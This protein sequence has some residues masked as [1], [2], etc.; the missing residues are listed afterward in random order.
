MNKN[1]RNMFTR[2]T[3]RDD[4]SDGMPLE[5]PRRNTTVPALIVAGMF[6]IFAA[7]LVQQVSRLNLHALGSIFELMTMLFELFWVLGWSVGV[8]ALAALT[9]FLLFFGESARVA[10]GRLIYVLNV[11]PFKMITEYELAR[12]RNL[13][14]EAEPDG[15]NARVRFE[16][17]EMRRG[18]GDTMPTSIAERNL[19]ILNSAMAGVTLAPA[20]E[21]APPPEFTPPKFEPPAELAQ[22]PLPLLS[23]LVLVAAN[24]IP[25]L[26]VL[27]GGWTLAEV[28]VLFWAESAVIGFYTLLKITVVAKWW[29]PFP[30]LFF[31]GHFGGFM[32]IHFLFIYELFVRGIN[33]ASPAPAAFEALAHMFTPLWIAFLALFLSHGVS[34]VVNFLGHREYENTT[35]SSLMQAPY[36]RIVVMQ[37]TLI[38]GGWVV[39]LLKDP[40]PALLL[41]IVI[42]VATDLRGHYGERASSTR[43]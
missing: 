29:A 40:M 15:E 5:L 25:L 12:V 28:M 20:D 10:R 1:F 38:L 33:A 36:G 4:A 35:V 34:F 24:L 26:S 18:L 23:M 30:G 27:M 14:I 21:F 8:L 7:V 11:G 41:L 43:K 6:A 2:F 32:A 9:V 42:K 13:R 3:L 22:R 16:Y 39:M 19:G 31:A 17:D 37:F